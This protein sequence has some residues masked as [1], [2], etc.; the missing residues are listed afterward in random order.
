MIFLFF[1]RA[2]RSTIAAA[3]L[4]ASC[5]F[6]ASPSSALDKT[7]A[8]PGDAAP[9]QSRA[10]VFQRVKKL[11]D[12]GQR[13]FADPGLSAS[14]S[15]SCA[16][17]HDAAKGFAPANALAVQLGGKNLD[18]AGLRA[19]PG[20]TYLQTTPRFTEHY[21]E[22][23]DDGDESVDAGPTGGLMWDGRINQVAAQALF[24]LFS[25]YE[26]ANEDHAALARVID[27]KYGAE[28][29]AIMEG[30]M[31]EGEDFALRAAAKA[32]QAYQ[33]TPAA[34]FPYNSKYDF[35][36]KGQV[37]LT[38]QEKHGLDL[39][40]D[41]KKGNCASCHFS[42]QPKP[43]VM[44]QFS[45]AGFI[46]LGLPR[47]KD[48]PRNADP[49]FFDLGLCGPERTDF[50]DQTDYCGTFKAPTLRNVALR[51]S[52]FHNGVF[53]DLREAVAFYV[54]RDVKPEK[55]YPRRIDGTVDKFNDLP[56]QYRANIN[57]DPPF[58]GKP[59]DAPAMTDA[60]IDDVVAF[61]KTLTDGY[62]PPSP[63]T[64]A[65]R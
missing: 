65:D 47:N 52:F 39:F 13:L 9:G 2:A 40:N 50:K 54:E 15:M 32:L 63:E 55:Y 29:R 1:G 8:Q 6:F 19:A 46:A 58:G 24:P 14:G 44:P 49:A 3:A 7:D 45:D 18:Q 42:A 12:V 56:V 35:F 27:A 51:Q 17:C 30:T 34:F 41:E 60:E 16:T 26:M 61:L 57:N 20:L 21:H 43:G 11:A 22:S 4:A 62:A 5:A 23:D 38:D 37:A 36:L 10:A 25:P 48:I 31:P 28:L 59:G 33:E 64:H 53:H